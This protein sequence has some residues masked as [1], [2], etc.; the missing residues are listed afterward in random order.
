M[1]EVVPVGIF[2]RLVPGFDE[3]SFEFN[4]L[5]G[6]EARDWRPEGTLCMMLVGGF[7]SGL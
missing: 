3:D 2:V 1:T 4:T 6:A 5:S 7:F